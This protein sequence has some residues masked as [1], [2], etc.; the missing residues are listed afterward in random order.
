MIQWKIL[1]ISVTLPGILLASLVNST[2]EE[3]KLNVFVSILPQAFFVERIGGEHVEVKVL[4]GPGQSPHT[5]EPTPRQMADLS[6][7]KVLFLMGVSFE[8]A[9]RDRIQAM[10]PGLKLVESHAGIPLRDIESHEHHAEHHHHHDSDHQ[11]SAGQK[12]PHVWLS[13]RHAKTIARNLGTTLGEI[14]PQHQKEFEANLALLLEELEQVDQEIEAMLSP[15]QNRQ[16]MVFH[17]AWG[18]F[19]DDYNLKQIPIEIEGKSPGAKSLAQLI[20]KARQENIRVVFV[21]KQFSTA[22]ANIIANAIGGKVVALDPLER[23]YIHNLQL[24]AKSLLE[25]LQ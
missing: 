19:A 17:P 18:Y 16:F 10:N 22:N 7:A 1:I 8:D 13:P 15:L 20:E 4:V 5:Y 11:C 9:W 3:D 23:D 6:R 12:D 25:G 2:A 21:Q 14:A 24:I